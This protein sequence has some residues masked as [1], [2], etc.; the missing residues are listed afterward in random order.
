MSAANKQIASRWHHGWGSANQR[1]VD[2]ACLAADFRAQ[3]PGHGWVERG[4]YVACIASALGGYAGGTLTVDEAVAEGDAVMLRL[5]W[6]LAEPG[7]AAK[8]NDA[9]PSLTGFAV[10]RFRDGRIVEHLLVV[11]RLAVRRQAVSRNHE[12]VASPARD[13]GIGIRRQA[14]RLPLRSTGRVRFLKVEDIEWVDAA[15]NYVR[16]HTLDGSTHVAREAIGEL[17]GRLDPTR[18]LR[19]HR[20]TIINAD[21]VRELE[22]SS[23]GNYVAILTSGQR[24]SVSRSFKDRLPALLGA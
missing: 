16:I 21:C 6:R 9:A 10:D 4:E 20:S 12:S 17:E 2:N 1:A 24:V 15:H 11:D 7:E 18:F 3:V 14:Q 5:T 13:H 22:L 8:P 19:I 23:Y